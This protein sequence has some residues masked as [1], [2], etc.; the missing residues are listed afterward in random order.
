M[1]R[2]P[3]RLLD[4]PSLS[5]DDRAL[6]DF[7]QREPAL[8]YDVAV[9]AARFQQLLAAS[10]LPPTSASGFALGAK[11]GLWLA[12]AVL[13]PTAASVVILARREPVPTLRAVSAPL[14]AAR[15]APQP[16]VPHQP[17]SDLPLSSA[18]APEPAVQAPATARPRPG[19]RPR[20]S[21]ARALGRASTTATPSPEPAPPPAAEAEP[22]RI[23]QPGPSSAMEEP[24]DQ[25]LEEVRALARARSLLDRDP[26][27]ALRQLAEIRQRFAAGYFLE[28]RRALEIIG[29]VRTGRA[30]P[31]REHAGAFLRD[32]PNGPFT[33]EIRALTRR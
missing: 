31:A 33:D 22:T 32:Y 13:L 9:G 27:A 21:E 17:V 14:P 30:A 12:L 8:E 4:D 11:S 26:A 28:E 15:P 24:V 19:R 29:L 16:G 7:G 5:P 23:A 6:L 25:T 2:E 18:A 3:T 20:S 1:T 10:A